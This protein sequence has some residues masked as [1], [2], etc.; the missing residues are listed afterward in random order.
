VN[1][2]RVIAALARRPDLWRAA[3]RQAVRMAPAGWWHRR[4][5]LPVPGGEYLQFRMVTQYGDPRHRPEPH[6]V[7]DYLAWCRRWDRTVGGR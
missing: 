2:L 7:V 5:F 6:D 4:P 1:W 3:G